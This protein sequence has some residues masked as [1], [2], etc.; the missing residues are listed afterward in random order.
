MRIAGAVGQRSRTDEAVAKVQGRL[1]HGP[2]QEADREPD[3]V[4]QARDAEH[5]PAAAF[6]W[7][8]GSQGKGEGKGKGKDKG[9]DKGKGK[10]KDKGKDKG[11]GKGKDKGKG[12]KVRRQR[13]RLQRRCWRR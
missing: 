2:E 13:T 10:G 4:V 6:K 11:K 5:Q 1:Q 9:K 12:R 3:G 8:Q 7:G